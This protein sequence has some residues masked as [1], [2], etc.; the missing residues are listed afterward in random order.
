MYSKQEY[1][2]YGEDGEDG[3]APASRCRAQGQM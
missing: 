3:G 1:G 2:E